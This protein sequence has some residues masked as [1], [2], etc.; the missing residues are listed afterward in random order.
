MDVS[1]ETATLALLSSIFLFLNSRSKTSLTKKKLWQGWKETNRISQVA[2]SFEIVLFLCG[3][4]K[5]PPVLRDF[6]GQKI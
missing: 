2:L 3:L 4:V 6:L 1:N 5:C